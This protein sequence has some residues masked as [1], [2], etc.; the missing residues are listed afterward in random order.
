MTLP[1]I[2]IGIATYNAEKTIK[3]AVHSALNQI[4]R[5]IEIIIVD[6]CSQDKTKEILT[7]LAYK[8]KEIKIFFNNKNLGIAFVRN[9]IISNSRGEF[10]AFFD[11]DD[12][13]LQNRLIMQYQRIVNYEKKFSP[14]SPVICHSNRKVFYPNGVIQIHPTIGINENN[15]SPSGIAVAERILLGKPLKDGYGSCPTCSQMARL[16]SYRKAGGFDNSFR[17]SEDTEMCIKW[18]LLGA[19][20]V[21]IKAP[22]VNQF[23]TN[24]PDKSIDI[25][26]KYSNLLIKKYENFIN[27]KGD[28]KF[29]LQW[30]KIKY[31]FSKGKFT[32]MTINLIY[33][34]IQ[35]PFETLRR[36]I[37]SFPRL[38]LNINF[39]TF[40]KG[41]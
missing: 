17:R 34:F 18:A 30:L 36:L 4:W 6:D 13:S 10:L 28:F 12:E 26:F 21:G 19:H 14:N 1:I 41:K 3:K 37:I 39:S 29:C 20:F 5:P 38:K 11:D 32:K 25:E 24:S 33:L 31:Q 8:N 2:T 35:N 22:L 9:K 7:D 16:S 23:M 27:K 40:H 15:Y